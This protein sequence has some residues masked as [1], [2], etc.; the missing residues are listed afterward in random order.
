VSAAAFSKGQIKVFVIYFTK[1]ALVGSDEP[2]P[3]SSGIGR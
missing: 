1:L 3:R 2:Y